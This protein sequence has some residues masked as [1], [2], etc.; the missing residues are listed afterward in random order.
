MFSIGFCYYAPTSISQEEHYFARSQTES[1][2]KSFMFKGGKLLKTLPAYQEEEC[3]IVR[4]QS[5]V[6]DIFNDSK[7]SKLYI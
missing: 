1:G 3:S 2:R 4:F 6:R 5:K 7:Y